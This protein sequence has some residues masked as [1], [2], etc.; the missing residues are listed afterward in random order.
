MSDTRAYYERYWQ[1]PD[2]AVPNYDPTTPARRAMLADALSDLPAGSRVLDMG[3][4][5]G[6]FTGHLAELGFRPVGVDLSE[7]AVRAA[8][9]RFPNAEFHAGT[10]EQFVDRYAGQFQAVWSTEVIEHVFDLYGFFA[11][12]NRF[13]APGGRLVLTTP[14]HGLIKNLLIDFRNYDHHYNPFGGHIRFFNKKSLT[15]CLIHCGFTPNRWAGIGR[16]W[17][18]YRSFFVVATKTGQ[19]LPP[20]PADS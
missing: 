14:Y 3:C 11:S 13:L 2:A 15:R 4:G 12:V 16:A 6:E 8:T 9:A 20:P 7:G 1:D 17:P 5:T 18:L 19:P 10:P